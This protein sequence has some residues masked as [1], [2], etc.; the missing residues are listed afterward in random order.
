MPKASSGGQSSV[1]PR[2]GQDGP[3]FFF[4]RLPL[5]VLLAGAL[6]VYTLGALFGS[7]VEAATVTGMVTRNGAAVAGAVVRAQRAPRPT[8]AQEDVPSARTDD[9]GLFSLT[10]ADGTWYL[11][12]GFGSAA[13]RA[14]DEFA[15]Y[16]GN[17]VT[18]KGEQRIDLGF[19]LVKVPAD[20]SIIPGKATGV[21]G[22]LVYQG[23]PL[24]KLYLYVYKDTRD[25]FRGMGHT[26]VPIGQE[27][28]FR[29]GLPPGEYYLIARQRK[30]GGM[31]GSLRKGDRVGYYY[32]NP[33]VVPANG[34]RSVE[35]ELTDIVE[36]PASQAGGGSTAG[37]GVSGEVR[38]RTG[39]GVAGMRLL[40]YADPGATGKPAFLSA[41]TGS[42]GRFSIPVDRPG[43]YYVIAR[44]F[45]GGAPQEGELTGRW[46][47]PQQKLKPLVLD[48][49]GRRLQ[50][51][52]VVAPYAATR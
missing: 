38:D 14:G 44:Q 30:A 5:P 12:A 2:R 31:L 43:T 7:A 49:P 17:P 47:D 45:P 35:I 8:P 37:M 52:I 24:G 27:G 33:V 28:R 3:A 36:E 46:S 6:S 41:E 9:A 21:E 19:N 22:R 32:G 50:L 26:V 11:M 20:G 15:F 29:A 1:S 4:G 10:L 34:M 42:D 40:L 16:G 13:P 25:G 51:S 18:L 39:K 48:S 23:K